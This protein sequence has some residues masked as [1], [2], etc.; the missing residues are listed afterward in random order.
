M[1]LDAEV[2][3]EDNMLYWLNTYCVHCLFFGSGQVV[4]SEILLSA[5]AENEEC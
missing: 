2:T 3:F 4:Y 1:L 5:G